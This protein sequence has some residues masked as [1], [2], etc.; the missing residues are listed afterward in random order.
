MATHFTLPKQQLVDQYGKPY[1][2]AKAYFYD[3]GTTTPKAVYSNAALTTP[4]ASPVVADSKG[5]FPVIY[6][7]AAQ[8]KVRIVT[9]AD[10]LIYE[11]DNIDPSLGTG[12]GALPIASGGTGANTASGARASLNVPSVDDFTD[13]T[14]ETQATVDDLEATI[15]AAL[16]LPRM[17]GFRGLKIDVTGDS[18][19]S[20][21]AEAAWVEATSGEGIRLSSVSKTI[22]A[23]SAG[24][25]GLD[26]GS[27][28]VNT[29]YAVWLIYNPTTEISAAMLSASG[30]APTMP[31]GFTMKMRFG[32]VRTDGSAN[33]RRT[34][35]YGNRVAYKLVSGTLPLLTFSTGVAALG[36]FIPST[37]A[38][39]FVLHRHVDGTTVT[40][41]APNSAYGATTAPLTQTADSSARINNNV[42]EFM[43]EVMNVYFVGTGTAT[44]YVYGWSDNL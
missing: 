12:I 2:G 37:A 11:A 8:Y 18:A 23:A 27:M 41:L 43:I 33:L 34:I 16:A 9:S 19:V 26:T 42:A 31:S 6:L 44:A 15:T 25:G 32:W 35:Q 20:F 7:S 36:D 39:V 40:G 30:T 29:W 13:F 3:P 4:H 38:S 24:G 17:P 28:A 22:N 21:T 5:Q 10:V 1:A 14:T